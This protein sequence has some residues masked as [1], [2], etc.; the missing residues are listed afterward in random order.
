MTHSRLLFQ[1]PVL[2]CRLSPSRTYTN[3]KPI[4]GSN[5]AQNPLYL[6]RHLLYPTLPIES[7]KASNEKILLINRHICRKPGDVL[8]VRRMVATIS[9]RRRARDAWR[10]AECIVLVRKWYNQHWGYEVQREGSALEP[11][12]YR[13]EVSVPL[14]ALSRWWLVKGLCVL[15]FDKSSGCDS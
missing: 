7:D 9:G 14:H 10:G 12:K 6:S 3:R 1:S 15:G 4:L 13:T 11:G 2:P 5:L 8:P